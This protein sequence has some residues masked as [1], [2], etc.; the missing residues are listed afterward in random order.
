MGSLPLAL[1]ASCAI[2]TS[3]GFLPAR[4]ERIERI[5]QERVDRSELPGAVVLLAR[6]GQV[7]LHRSFGFRDL[8]SKALLK[9]DDLFRLASATKILTSAALL[10]LYEEGRF[11]L[12]DPVSDYLP[13]LKELKVQASD[14]SI[15]TAER[16]VTVRDLLRHTAGYGYGFREPQ[17]SAYRAAGIMTPGPNPE[18]THQGTLQEWAVRLATVPLADEPGTRFEYG[19]GSDLAGLLIERLSNQSLDRFLH[20][21]L[22]APLRMHDTGFAV[23]DDELDRLTSLYRAKDGALEAIDRAPASP[24][25]QLPKAFSGG[26]GWDNLGN[27]GLV[28]TAPDMLRFLQMLLNEGELD[29]ARVL[30]PSTV[31]MMFRNHLAGLPSPEISPGIGFGLGYAVVEKPALVGEAVSEGMMWWAGST[32]VHYWIDPKRGFIGLYFTQVLPFGHLDMMDLVRQ[33]SVQALE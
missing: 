26:G 14:G 21:R 27:G 28:S 10:T 30:S 3:P 22:F 19:F 31:E 23:P 16:Q 12:R 33:L 4:L 18:W 7:A 1:V 6:D 17:Q 20:E 15:R 8:E 11:R 2:L 25:R 24:M 32:N 9:P 29:G 13:E 5:L